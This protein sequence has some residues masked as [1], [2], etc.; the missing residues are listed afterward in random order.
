MKI[1]SSTCLLSLLLILI[2]S[3]SED[4]KLNLPEPDDKIIIDG[5]IENNQYVKVL[6]TRNAPYFSSIDSASIRDLVLSRAKV[7]LSDG[8]NSEV[9]ILRRNDEYFPPY[10]FEGNEI[11]GEIG[12][13]YTVTAEY[14][15]K[16]AWASTSIP[17]RVRLDTLYFNLEAGSDS[18]G[19]VNIRFTDPAG[20][21]DYYRVLSK[22][23]GK[24]KRFV[25]P[26]I[27][28]FDDKYF[29]GQKFG[30]AMKRGPTSF[31]SSKS[32]KYFAIGD[33]ADIKFCTIDN[34]SYDF[35]STF[36]DEILN[37]SN[38]FASSL[39]KIKSN[40]QGDGLGVFTGYGMYF[41]TL[42]IK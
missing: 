16:K 19:S 33:T 14:G 30:F 18:L 29:S 6:L 39:A 36:Q 38:P 1:S 37:S 3:C 28:G 11:L 34:E 32:N 2:S 24:D 20:E 15:G 23:R 12:K 40:V 27:M 4:L 10:V 31:I 13:T 7:T 17:P 25:S 41:Y 42:I 26:M 8:V 21:K 22:V 5:W 9:L 35:W